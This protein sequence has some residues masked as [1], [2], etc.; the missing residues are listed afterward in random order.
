MNT[1]NPRYSGFPSP[2]AYEKADYDLAYQKY[3][4]R[5]ADAGDFNFYFVG[6]VNEK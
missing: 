1:G 6:N 3:H 4:E 2:E 5:F